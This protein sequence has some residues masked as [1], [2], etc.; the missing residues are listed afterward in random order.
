MKEILQLKG[1]DCAACAAELEKQISA[2]DGIDAASI[3]F[4]SQKLTIEYQTDEAKAA[5]LAMANAFEE[6][7]VVDGTQTIQPKK[8]SL[9]KRWWE[10]LVSACL[11]TAAMIWRQ[12]I[13]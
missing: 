13:T 12:L 9:D 4:V 2:I 5:A 1:L 8:K 11:L 7:C 10:I 6:V 3:A